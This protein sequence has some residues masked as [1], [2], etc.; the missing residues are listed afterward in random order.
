M[1]Q[2]S[3]SSVEEKFDAVVESFGK[4]LRQAIVRLCPKDLGLQ[5]DD[6]EQEARMRLWRA[7]ESEREIENLTSYLY[8]IAATATI[9]AVR[10]ARTRYEQQLILPEGDEEEQIVILKATSQSPETLAE[11]RELIR[12]IEN[13]LAQLPENRRR[14]VGLHLQ[15]M[16]NQETANA[17]GW[18][19]PKARNLIYRGLKDLRELLKA[20]NV[21]YEEPYD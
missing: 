17:L 18:T 15:G 13:T 21:E 11:E 5:Y 12:K 9:D 4:F 19:E 7:L 10:H 1:K 20:E 6:I 14:A 2:E 8:R 3:R 16:T